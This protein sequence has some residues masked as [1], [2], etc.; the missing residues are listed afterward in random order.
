[1][2]IKNIFELEVAIDLCESCFNFLNKFIPFF[3]IDQLILKPK[4]QKYITVE[5]LFVKE[6]SDM[7][8]MKMLEKQEQITVMLKLKFIRN[9]VKLNI[10][11]NTQETVIFD[12]KEMLGILDLRLLGYCKIKQGVYSKV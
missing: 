1:M 7:S 3:P 10:T 6:I 8:I 5:A 11:N 4:E 9:R 12:P 2:G